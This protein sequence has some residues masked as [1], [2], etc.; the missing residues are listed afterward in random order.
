M[1]WEQPA[2]RTGNINTGLRLISASATMK[3]V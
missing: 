3:P 2:G 1:L